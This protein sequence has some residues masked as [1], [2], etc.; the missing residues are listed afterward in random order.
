LST[1]DNNLIPIGIQDGINLSASLTD[2]TSGVG[3]HLYV[4]PDVIQKRTYGT[5]AD[6]YSLGV[7]FFEMCYPMKSG[8]ERAQVLSSIRLPKPRFP[9]DWNRDDKAAQTQIIEL[10]HDPEDRPEAEDLLR[11]SLLPE[12]REEEYYAEAIRKVADPSSIHYP[13]LMARLF[14]PERTPTRNGTVLLDYTYDSVDAY[15]DE[16]QAWNRVV[17]DRL[18]QLFARHGA[19]ELNTPLLAPAFFSVDIDN[20]SSARLLDGQGNLVSQLS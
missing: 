8:M 2:M 19:I 4:S 9:T 16:S 13:A 12:G 17:K 6:V 1:T 10:K 15:L 20:H 18:S 7:I 11:S 14:N 5:K 3:T